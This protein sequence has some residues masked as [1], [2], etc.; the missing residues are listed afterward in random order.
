VVAGIDQGGDGE[1]ATGGLPGERDAGRVGAV[2][3][4]LVGGQGVLDRGR[5][6]VLGGEPVVHRDDPGAGPPADLG[7]QAG[8]LEGVL[9]HVH[10]AVE[11]QDDMAGVDSV[12][13]DLGGRD[14]AQ[15]GLRSRSRLRAAAAPMPAPRAAAAAR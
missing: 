5:V 11:V 12:D 15:R 2:L 13:G 9:Q 4:G 10:A 3:Q 7:S 8:D 6:R 14:A 1:A